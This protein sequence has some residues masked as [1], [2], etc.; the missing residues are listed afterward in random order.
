M[1]RIYKKRQ[2]SVKK[3]QKDVKKRQKDPKNRVAVN[4][5]V[6]PIL[7]DTPEAPP[8]PP[9]PPPP[10]ARSAW[11]GSPPLWPDPPSTPIQTRSNP[12]PDPIRP[13]SRPN[14]DPNPIQT[15]SRPDPTPIQTRSDPDPDLSLAPIGSFHLFVQNHT[16][17]TRTPL[18]LPIVSFVLPVF[19]HMSLDPKTRD[20][21]EFDPSPNPYFLLF[22][23]L[24]LISTNEQNS[25]HLQ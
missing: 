22:S 8:P 21:P 6:C 17:T 20:F 23:A 25:T 15:R 12:D 1:Q 13:R 5:L 4:A 9:P 19:S 16:P 2:K 10:S 18:R 14:R 7:S 3:R 11:P 24:W